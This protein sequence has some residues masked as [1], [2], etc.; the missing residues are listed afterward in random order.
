MI[1]SLAD[2]DILSGCEEL[3]EIADYFVINLTDA[4]SLNYLLKKDKL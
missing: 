4:S 2:N 1:P 3:I